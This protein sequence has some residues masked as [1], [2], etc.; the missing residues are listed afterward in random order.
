MA[1][2]LHLLSFHAQ[3]NPRDV[4]PEE[5]CD[6][7]VEDNAQ[8]PVPARHLKEVVG[9]PRPSPGDE[10]CKSH[11]AHSRDCATYGPSESAMCT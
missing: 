4:R 3:V 1:R 11:T 5:E 8:A 7:P 10:A 9:P 6:G 2:L